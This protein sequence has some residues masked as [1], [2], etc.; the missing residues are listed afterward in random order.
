MMSQVDVLKLILF[1]M[2]YNLDRSIVDIF[3]AHTTVQL[4][5]AM[6]KSRA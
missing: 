2:L 5:I 3:I 1:T 4:T 6:Y